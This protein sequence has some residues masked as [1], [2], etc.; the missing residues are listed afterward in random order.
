M[1][2]G[3]AGITDETVNS[4]VSIVTVSIPVRRGFISL[5]KVFGKRK[6]ARTSQENSGENTECLGHEG[7]I[8]KID[9]D[10]VSL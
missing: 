6:I 3:L 5:E 7:Y 10:R 2:F 8:G 1:R 4:S 9:Q